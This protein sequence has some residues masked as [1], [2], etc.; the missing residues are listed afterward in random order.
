MINTSVSKKNNIVRSAF[1]VLLKAPVET[2]AEPK[3]TA[4]R[5]KLLLL[6]VSVTKLLAAKSIYKDAIGSKAFGV[7]EYNSSL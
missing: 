3:L 1:I 5:K 4:Y 7:G 2:G 6:F